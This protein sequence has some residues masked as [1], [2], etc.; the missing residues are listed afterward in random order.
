MADAP[1]YLLERWQDDLEAMFDEP[2][3]ADV[4]GWL[5]QRQAQFGSAQGAR[6]AQ[7]L[8]GKNGL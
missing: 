1:R 2:E 7:R 6:E 3:R 8:R 5:I 4:L